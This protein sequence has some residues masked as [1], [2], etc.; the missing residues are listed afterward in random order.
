MLL[1]FAQKDAGKQEAIAELTLSKSK[2]QNV[3]GQKR[4]SG[5]LILKKRYLRGVEST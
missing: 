2:L 3:T 5:V 4:N 1:P